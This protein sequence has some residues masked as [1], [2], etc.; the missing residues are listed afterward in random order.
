MYDS[1]TPNLRH[2]RKSKGIVHGY[3][4][5]TEWR[6]ARRGVHQGHPCV[7][8]VQHQAGSPGL[9]GTGR[10]PQLR[11]DSAGKIPNK[12]FRELLERYSRE[13][14]INKRGAAR[15]QKMIDVILRDPVAD[16]S[17]CMLAPTDGRS[18]T[19]A[20]LGLDSGAGDDNPLTCL[21]GGAARVGLGAYQPGQ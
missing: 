16:V 13:V 10:D 8:D 20:G 1:F 14:S 18:A 21:L 3:I 11:E 2:W 7:G 9:G 15:E 19:E 12:P 4:Q 17:L 5:K 6:L